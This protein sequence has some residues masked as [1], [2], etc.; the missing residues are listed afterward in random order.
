MA[1]NLWKKSSTETNAIK[2]KVTEHLCEFALLQMKERTGLKEEIFRLYYGL[3]NFYNLR[4]DENHKNLPSEDDR[5]S[6]SFFSRVIKSSV[7]YG[8]K[9]R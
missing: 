7:T 1:I 5:D 2:N 3:K 6:D 4:R 9:R 8:Q